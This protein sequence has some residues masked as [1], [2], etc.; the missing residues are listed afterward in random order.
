MIWGCMTTDGP[1]YS[2]QVRGTMDA[3]QYQDMILGPL[4]GTLTWYH[5]DKR[6]VIYQHDNDP[7]HTARSTVQLL[8]DRG[9]NVLDWPSQSPDLN[10]IEHLWAQVKNRMALDPETPK[11]TE[12]LWLKFERIWNEITKEACANLID[13]MPDRI[14]AVIKAR[15]GHTKY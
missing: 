8:E 2:A 11:T 5:L 14:I 10:P 12:E 3:R 4:E 1:G 9:W 13:S 15:G 6:R 7:K